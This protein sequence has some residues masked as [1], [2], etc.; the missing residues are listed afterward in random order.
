MYIRINV[1]R[2]SGDNAK[3]Y[4]SFDVI[5]HC[6]ALCVVLSSWSKTERASKRH[7][8]AQAGQSYDRY[9]RGN[10]IDESNVELPEDVAQEAHSKLVSCIKVGKWQADFEAMQ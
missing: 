1:E 2:S 5:E 7:K 6:G 9:S 8:W 4:W 3:Q 10:S